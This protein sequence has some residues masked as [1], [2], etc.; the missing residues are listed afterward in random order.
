MDA[1]WRLRSG[2]RA[3]EARREAQEELEKL[4]EFQKLLIKL[5]RIR[6]LGEETRESWT[7]FVSFYLFWCP[8]C[9]SYYK[10][11]RHG[12]RPC[13]TCYRCM[14]HYSL[15]PWWTPVIELRDLIRLMIKTRN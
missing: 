2:L 15:E 13:V 8:E 11:Y 10:D 9:Q 14:I 3:Q 7:G 1:K 6:Y 12:H 5:G 4:T